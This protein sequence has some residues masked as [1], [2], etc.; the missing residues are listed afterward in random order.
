M[1]KLQSF[2]R[3]VLQL[4]LGQESHD[5]NRGELDNIIIAQQG[6]LPFSKGILFMLSS[7]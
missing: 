5:F 7:L 6:V 4:K 2:Q 3:V 1:F